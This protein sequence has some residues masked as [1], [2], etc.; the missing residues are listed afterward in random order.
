ML[1]CQL[2]EMIDNSKEWAK[3][4]GLLQRNEVHGKE[5]W[6][7]PT[8]RTFSFENKNAQSSSATGSMTVQ[9]PMRL[10]DIPFSSQCKNNHVIS[11]GLGIPCVQDPD[12]TLL[13]NDVTEDTALRKF[14]VIYNID[15]IY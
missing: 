1:V 2:R 11:L 13:M 14:G 3:Q 5:E 9:D 4:R 12:A 10:S 6:K 7:I 8:D 15:L